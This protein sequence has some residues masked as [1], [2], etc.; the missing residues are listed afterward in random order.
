MDER[1]THLERL[2]S[3]HSVKLNS[4]DIMKDVILEDYKAMQESVEALTNQL[5]SINMILTSSQGYLKG[6][7]WVISVLGSIFTLILAYMAIK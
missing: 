6:G 7:M 5:H 2:V 4:L 3:E 1:I